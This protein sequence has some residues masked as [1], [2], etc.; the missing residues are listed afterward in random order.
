MENFNDDIQ[1]LINLKGEVR[2][3]VFKTDLEFILSKKGEEGLK[4]IKEELKKI[5]IVIDYENIKPMDFY[6]IGLRIISLLII[7]KVFN[8]DEKDIEEMGFF[9]SRVSSMTRFFI[10]FFFSLE[11]L[12]AKVPTLWGRHYTIG[13]I[14]SFLNKKEKYGQIIIKDFLVHPILCT[15]L[16][17]YFSGILKMAINQPVI[18]QE[19]KCPFKGD[20]FHLFELRW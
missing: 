4:K 15:Y 17:G 2:G 12:A 8:L 6:P 19:I 16:K 18:C 14:E 11:N 1:K 9:A 20:D 3:A 13:K 10:K 7:K 5:N